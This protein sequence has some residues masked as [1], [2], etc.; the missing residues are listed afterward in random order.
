[1][2]LPSIQS[3]KCTP[4]DYLANFASFLSDEE[5]YIPLLL[6]LHFYVSSAACT[7]V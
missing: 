7:S 1:M 4:L 3:A 2:L 6:V 5:F